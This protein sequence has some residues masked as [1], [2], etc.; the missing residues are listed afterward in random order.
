MD[1]CFRATMSNAH[2]A[3]YATHQRKSSYPKDFSVATPEEFVKRFGGN[4][5]INKVRIKA[6][7]FFTRYINL[8]KLIYGVIEYDMYF[9][10]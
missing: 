8:R 5:V 6:M 3:S 2:L 4:L 10:Y 1:I 7:L 9:L